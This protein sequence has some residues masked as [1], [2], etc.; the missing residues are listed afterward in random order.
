MTR[1]GLEKSTRLVNLKRLTLALIEGF[2]GTLVS[3]DCAKRDH[4]IAQRLAVGLG[5]QVAPVGAH[6]ARG[7]LHEDAIGVQRRLD[8]I[9]QR[10]GIVGRELE[11]FAGQRH[12]D[13]PRS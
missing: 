10:A 9:L 4:V 12:R 8:P 5:V 7:A 2:S 1:T 11:H 6:V 3:T 13:G